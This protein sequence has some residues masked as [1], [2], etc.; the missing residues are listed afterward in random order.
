MKVYSKCQ[1]LISSEQRS[2]FI[3]VGI[4]DREI[5]IAIESNVF[6]RIVKRGR[7]SFDGNRFNAMLPEDPK[8]FCKQ[9]LKPLLIQNVPPKILH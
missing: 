5:D 9:K 6:G 4:C 3:V 1:I 7:V 8:G 2:G